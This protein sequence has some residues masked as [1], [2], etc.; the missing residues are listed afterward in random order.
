MDPNILLGY[1]GAFIIGITLGLI[2]GGGSI[3]TVPVL[4][5]L[6]EYDAVT[7]TGYSLFIVGVTS[8]FGAFR[9]GTFGQVDYRTA[10]LF[11]APSML[12]V[13]ATRKFLLPIIPDPVWDT[14]ALVLSKD[15]MLLTLFALL[16]LGTSWSMIRGGGAAA[17][18]DPPKK[19]PGKVLLILTEGIVVG[20]LTGLVGAGGG[21]LI[22]PALVLLTRMPM[23]DAIG[24]S[25]LV[26]AIKSLVGFLGELGQGVSIEFGFLLLFSGVAVFGAFLGAWWAR[27]IRARYLK[28]AFG[29]FVILMAVAILVREWG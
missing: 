16:M 13:Y 6:M 26:I 15:V 18:K 28:P 20:V 25:L 4:V 3:L 19:T 8:A 2:G 5:Y 11:A 23:K 10:L 22:V 7:A 24:T 29:V 21:F 27:F 14:S 12:A 1:L 17:T 9:Y